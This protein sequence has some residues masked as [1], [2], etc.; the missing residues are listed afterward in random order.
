LE[1]KRDVGENPLEDAEEWDESWFA[2]W[3]RPKEDP[4]EEYGEEKDGEELDGEVGR[5]A[6]GACAD[7]DECELDE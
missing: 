6:Y 1:E 4:G 2:P 7:R 3:C 5:E